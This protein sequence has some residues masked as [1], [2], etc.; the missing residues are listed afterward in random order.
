MK[1]R[2]SHG[3]LLLMGLALLMSH[4][5]FA[6]QTEDE[7]DQDGPSY[8]LLQSGVDAA[9]IYDFELERPGSKALTLHQHHQWRWSEDSSRPSIILKYRLIHDD[10]HPDLDRQLGQKNLEKLVFYTSGMLLGTRLSAGYQEV[11]WGENTLMPVLDVVNPRSFNHPRG[12]YDTAAKIPQAMA[13]AEWQGETLSL[14][15]IAVPKPE[16][17]Q[18]PKTASVFAI[19][20]A[21]EQPPLDPEY[22]GRFGAYVLG[23]DAKT[24]YFRHGPRIPAYRLKAF[25]RDGDL[26]QDTESEETI[27]LSGSYA[28]EA[29]T[30]RA[31]A[32]ETRNMPATGIG[33]EVEHTTLRR[34][35]V[36]ANWA[37]LSQHTLG[38]ELHTDS[39][40]ERPIAYTENAFVAKSRPSQTL[41]WLGLTC[42]FRLMDGNADLLLVYYRGLEKNDEIRR[43]SSNFAV[44]DHWSIN[45]EYQRT[46]AESR[47]PLLLLNKRESL[48]LTLSWTY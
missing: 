44:S 48:G 9:G 15:L 6:D 23:I 17:L 22:G 27:G 5:A 32:A 21:G 2:V 40:K 37:T 28:G 45:V 34:S 46:R 39:W 25:S 47:S 19:V 8:N 42:N 38:L 3:R 24:Y 29:I 4:V 20:P 1:A 33:T 18:Q 30:V 26:L 31:D 43:V 12:F 16:P 35:I 7:E 36:G 14:E 41:N 13:R 11:S 10:E